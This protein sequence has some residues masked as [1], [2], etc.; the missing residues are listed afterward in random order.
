MFD[1]FLYPANRI[2]RPAWGALGTLGFR[3]LGSLAAR[4]SLLAYD[5][6]PGQS[7][8]GFNRDALPVAM[9]KKILFFLRMYRHNP[10]DRMCVRCVFAHFFEFLQFFRPSCA[11]GVTGKRGFKTSG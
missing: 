8:P 2:L 9:D 7:E 10:V 11:A 6:D 3:R 4:W 1:Q 5:P